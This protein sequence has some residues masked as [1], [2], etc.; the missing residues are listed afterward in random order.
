MYVNARR[1]CAP[2][3]NKK[4]LEPCADR[5]C[6]RASLSFKSYLI[7]RSGCVTARRNFRTVYTSSV[8]SFFSPPVS[9]DENASRG[10][11]DRLKFL[12]CHLLP[13]DLFIYLSLFD[14]R[15][16]RLASD[17]NYFYRG[18]W[19]MREKCRRYQRARCFLQIFART[20]LSFLGFFNL[21]KKWN[22]EFA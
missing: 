4:R 12:H 1:T 2:C 9:R 14:E 21:R 18:M 8:L 6:I 16:E 7:R 19:K 3:A 20:N 5:S 15:L 22:N 11:K 13:F 17:E 10:T